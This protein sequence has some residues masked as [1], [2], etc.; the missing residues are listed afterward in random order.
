MSASA[1]A[2][3]VTYEP[4]AGSRNA[5]SSRRGASQSKLTEE[6]V[7]FIRVVRHLTRPY[8]RDQEL[9]FTGGMSRRKGAICRAHTK[10]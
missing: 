8:A 1:A 4:M 3:K 6:A 7:R 9:L 2:F 10:V 5:Q